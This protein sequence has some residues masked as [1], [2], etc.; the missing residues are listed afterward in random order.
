MM[1]K[2]FRKAPSFFAELDENYKKRKVRKVDKKHGKVLVGDGTF[3]SDT[4]RCFVS[5]GKKTIRREWRGDGDFNPRYK[6]IDKRLKSKFDRRHGEI[7]ED[8]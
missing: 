1:G 8:D 5:N 6:K 7:P 4:S 2:T 3:A